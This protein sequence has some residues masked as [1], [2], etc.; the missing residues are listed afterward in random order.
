MK[1]NNNKPP[2]G[3][4]K[5]NVKKPSEAPKAGATAG[6][7]GAGG[8]ADSI[9]ISKQGKEAVQLIDAIGKLPDVRT[10][11]VNQVR[12]AINSGNYKVDAGKVAQKMISEI[13]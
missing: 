6:G 3:P 4:E 2:E 9:R 10:D 11:R 1:I 7:A 8:P 5:H 13:V 12:E